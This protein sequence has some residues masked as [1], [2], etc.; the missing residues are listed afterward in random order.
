[1]FGRQFQPNAPAR[2]E[3]LVGDR[4]FHE[5]IRSLPDRRLLVARNDTYVYLL[6]DPGWIDRHRWPERGRV[7][8]VRGTTGDLAALV[9]GTAPV[10]GS[11]WNAPGCVV[12]APDGFVTVAVPPG[13]IGGTRISADGMNGYRVLQSRD[14]GTFAPLATL[15]RVG[16]RGMRARIVWWDDQPAPR[17]L[18]VEP[19]GGGARYSI[20]EIEFLA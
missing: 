6:D 10:E 4:A 2:R 20:G 7:V 8:A 16:T 13:A 17:Y 3:I 18:R 15:R 1:M 12:V 11:R 5:E 14:G 9:D 19:Q